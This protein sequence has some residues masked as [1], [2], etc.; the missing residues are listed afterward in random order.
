MQQV[1]FF[2][3]VDANEHKLAF[4]QADFMGIYADL[5]NRLCEEQF[6]TGWMRYTT[7]TLKDYNKQ[8]HGHLGIDPQQLPIYRQQ[9]EP[10][11]GILKLS[12]LR[13]HLQ[14]HEHTTIRNEWVRPSDF[15]ELIRDF[16]SAIAVLQKAVMLEKK[17]FLDVDV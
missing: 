12:Q 9:F 2:V 6:G 14:L 1:W 4:A 13:A 8:L 17:W 5:M 3:V 10:E 15:G 11:E 16:D 7:F